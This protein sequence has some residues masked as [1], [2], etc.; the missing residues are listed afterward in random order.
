MSHSSRKSALIVGAVLGTALAFLTRVA[1]QAGFVYLAWNTV[2]ADALVTEPISIWGACVLAL[3]AG[4]FLE[5]RS[6]N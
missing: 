3:T 6:K 1:I 2:L 5:G 4:V